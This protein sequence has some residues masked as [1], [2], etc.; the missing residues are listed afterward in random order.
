MYRYDALTVLDGRTEFFFSKVD[1][2]IT[3]IRY[4]AEG[5]VTRENLFEK[6]WNGALNLKTEGYLHINT[7]DLAALVDRSWNLFEQT[8]KFN[9]SVGPGARYILTT[10]DGSRVEPIIEGKE[11]VKWKPKKDFLFLKGG[12]YTLS[13]DW[14]YTTGTSGQSSLLEVSGKHNVTDNLIFGLTYKHWKTSL[15]ENAVDDNQILF[16]VSYETAE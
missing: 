13:E 11:S 10:T 16:E 2:S 7:V 15:L 12:R 3:A 6:N 1:N 4:L 8:V 9:A 14:T 5:K